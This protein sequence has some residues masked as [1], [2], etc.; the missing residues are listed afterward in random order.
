MI[1]NTDIKGNSVTFK[2]IAFIR[3]IVPGSTSFPWMVISTEPEVLYHFQW[4]CGFK[5]WKQ[6]PD[7]QLIRAS[8]SN[9][10]RWMPLLGVAAAASW[11]SVI[12]GVLPTYEEPGLGFHYL[13]IKAEYVF[14]CPRASKCLYMRQNFVRK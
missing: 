12:K 2:V 1:S 5:I 7:K 4:K 3:N 14:S 9:E 6:S 13:T 11:C 10:V 8:Y